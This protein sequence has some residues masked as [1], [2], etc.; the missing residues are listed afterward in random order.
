MTKKALLFGCG[1][2]WGLWFTKHLADS[3]YHVNLVSSSDVDYP[4]VTNHKINWIQ[5]NEKSIKELVVKEEYDLIFFNQNSGGGPGGEDFSLT[6][7]FPIEHWNLHL[8]IN[9][10]LPYTVIK[11]LG[12]SISSH[13]KIGWMLTGLIS[14]NDSSLYQYA[15]YA[16]LKSTN[17]HIMRGFSQYHPGIFFAI[18]PIWFPESDYKKDAVQIVKVIEHLSET[19]SG[20][21]FMKDGSIWL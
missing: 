13:T 19:D 3:G 12:D 14:G 1:S 20:K 11:H 6:K 17:L 4:N 18:N 15:G 9:C 2:K 21:S 16:S 8:W 7:D 10:Q 5:S